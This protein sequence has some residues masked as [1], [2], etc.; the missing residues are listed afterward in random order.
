MKQLKETHPLKRKVQWSDINSCFCCCKKKS[1][2]KEEKQDLIS[3]EKDAKAEDS[4]IEESDAEYVPKGFRENPFIRS[5]YGAN[6]YF[7]IQYSIIKLFMIITIILTPV[8]YI[9]YTASD[10]ETKHEVIKTFLGHFGGAHTMCDHQRMKFEQL[11]VRCE[12]ATVFDSS[13]A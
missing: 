11:E 10:R 9:N 8:M 4:H 2:K 7:D 3:G 5:G 6:S 1:S 13:S 12:T